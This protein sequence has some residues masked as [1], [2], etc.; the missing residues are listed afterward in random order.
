MNITVS[1]KSGLDVVLVLKPLKIDSVDVQ[2][3]V[4]LPANVIETAKRPTEST[5]PKQI[6]QTCE[7]IQ[8]HIDTRQILR[9]EQSYFTKPFHSSKSP[10][11]PYS[12]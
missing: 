9:S 10:S 12:T 1:G 5:S 2:V 7:T 6:I 4:D 11:P 8:V 3:P